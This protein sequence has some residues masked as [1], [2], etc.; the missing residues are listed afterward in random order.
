[1]KNNQNHNETKLKITASIFAVCL[2]A[3]SLTACGGSGGNNTASK[4]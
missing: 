4:K 3:V 2:V 1:M